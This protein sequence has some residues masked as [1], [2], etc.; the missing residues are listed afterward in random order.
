[1]HNALPFLLEKMKI[2]K[3][4]KFLGNLF[5]KKEDILT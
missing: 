4:N 1:M 2:G 5:N 3:C